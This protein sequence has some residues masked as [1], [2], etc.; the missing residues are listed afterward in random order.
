MSTQTLSREILEEV[1]DLNAEQQRRVL[2]FVRSLKL[3]VGTSGSAL[4]RFAG[5]IDGADLKRI[6]D[7]IDTGCEGISSD[8]W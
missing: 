3:P 8:D 6:A 5:I 4:L 7:A 2:G 1:S